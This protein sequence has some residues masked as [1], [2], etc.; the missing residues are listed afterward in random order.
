MVVNNSYVLVRFYH[1]VVIIDPIFSLRN[2]PPIPYVPTLLTYS[3][4]LPI[5]F[6]AYTSGKDK[7]DLQDIF[8]Y[9]QS[10]SINTESKS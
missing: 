7:Q 4:V 9:V 6:E 1:I 5:K 8:Y 10:A 2:C 3:V